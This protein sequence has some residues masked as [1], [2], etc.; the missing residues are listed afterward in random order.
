MPSMGYQIL[1][2]VPNWQMEKLGPSEVIN[3]PDLGSRVQIQGM[4]CSQ[5]MQKPLTSMA[6]FWA[7][8]ADSKS[9]GKERMALN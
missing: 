1:S 8:G 2:S 6:A 7:Q 3:F 9:Q 5:F 4:F